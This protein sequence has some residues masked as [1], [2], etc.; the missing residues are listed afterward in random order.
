[1]FHKYRARLYIQRGIYLNMHIS[2]VAQFYYME[3]KVNLTI[4]KMRLKLWKI[5]IVY[6]RKHDCKLIIF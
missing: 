2:Y 4:D 5:L 6:C 1:M 3:L